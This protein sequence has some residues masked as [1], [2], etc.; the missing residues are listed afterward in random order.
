MMKRTLA[1]TFAVLLLS[2]VF[3]A[4]QNPP[5]TPKPGPEQKNLGYFAGDWKTT[6]DLKPGPMGP[7]G[8]FTGTDHVEFCRWRQ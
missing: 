4:G 7:G 6:G 3:A 2:S 1:V 8:K 5:P